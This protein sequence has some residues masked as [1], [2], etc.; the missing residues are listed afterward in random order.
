MGSFVHASHD[1]ETLKMAN[2]NPWEGGII[3]EVTSQGSIC[4]CILKGDVL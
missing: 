1:M 2:V 3:I 4:T